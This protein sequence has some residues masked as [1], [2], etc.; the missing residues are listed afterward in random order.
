MLLMK[1]VNVSQCGHKEECC[2]PIEI[3]GK[4]GT[5]LADLEPMTLVGKKS[6][7]MQQLTSI[8]LSR[9]KVVDGLVVPSVVDDIKSIYG[10]ALNDS[11]NMKKIPPVLQKKGAFLNTPPYECPVIVRDAYKYA[12]KQV[13][14]QYFGNQID[15]NYLYSDLD[16]LD[17]F[18]NEVRKRSSYWTT[19]GTLNGR[20]FRIAACA[21]GIG[22][23]TINA[24]MGYSR[25]T[26]ELNPAG[27][28]AVKHIEEATRRMY[29]CMGYGPDDLGKERSVIDMQ[30]VLEGAYLGSAAGLNPETFIKDTLPTGEPLIITSTGKKIDVIEEDFRRIMDYL[31]TGKLWETYFSMVQKI[32]NFFGWDKQQNDKVWVAWKN[33]ERLFN[34]PTSTFILAEKLVS[35]L[36]H[37][38]ERGKMIKIGSKLAFGGMD[39]LA[40]DLGVDIT[41]E[42]KKILVE[43]DL[44][45]Q[46]QSVH[47]FFV[48]LY[49]EFMLVH[50][51][52]NSVDYEAKVRLL[53]YLVPRM[54]QRLT[55]LYS[56]VWV[57]HYGGVPSGCYN[58]SHMDSWIM[59][60]YFFLFCTMQLSNA[61]EPDKDELDALVS[62]VCIVIYGDDHIYNKGDTRVSHYLSGYNFQTF[63]KSAFD[64]D[65]KEI[66]DGV[67]Y[68]SVVDRGRIVKRGCCFLKQF[69]VL[70]P[71][72]DKYPGQPRYLPFREV[73]EFMIRAAYGRESETRTEKEV[74]LA[75][76][77]HAYGTYASN[78]IAYDMLISAYTYILSRRQFDWTEDQE[79]EKIY[80]T[81]S[82]RKM[83]NQG[84]TIKDLRR[85]FPTW[86]TLIAHN[87]WDP[88][89]HKIREEE[90]P[91]HYSPSLPAEW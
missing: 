59:G 78:R 15:W 51:D 37:M 31:E 23:K 3:Q 82:M 43:G 14:P 36:R 13:L 80:A 24:T 35:K 84:I 54:V 55:R 42:L 8:I 89:Y 85:G 30:D 10:N 74:C 62:A 79:L 76:I 64:V 25:K 70:N 46:D 5:P 69:A 61:P 9:Y 40:I 20:P 45:N 83:R 1:Y 58:T 6:T 87:K 4:P 38:K 2:C 52:P 7:Q 18:H 91:A 32:E 16:D 56:D 47:A 21:D 11:P 34:I 27:K 88:E 90:F 44:K 81:K 71:Y 65:L 50:E 17:P 49:M 68:L 63:L 26:R 39:Q 22:L 75:L 67:P 41:N 77:G 33:K 66:Y 48:N 19:F 60:L 73:N 28:E 12:D 29:A 86:E 72:R 53:Q 57:L